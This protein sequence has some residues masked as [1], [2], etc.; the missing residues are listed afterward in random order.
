MD[1][2]RCYHFNNFYFAGL[3]AGIQSHHSF[4]EI[5]N[6]HND[7]NKDHSFQ[8]DLTRKWAKSD[9]TV[10]V[11]NGGMQMHL[12]ELEAFLNHDDNKYPW[13]AFRESKEAAN[14]A[15]TN[16]GIILPDYIFK[17]SRV[18]VNNHPKVLESRGVGDGFTFKNKEI[19]ILVVD[20]G[21]IVSYKPKN[22]AFSLIKPVLSSPYK[23]DFSLK[24]HFYSNF[25]VEF[26]AR[27]SL[28]PLMS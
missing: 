2:T 18:I 28:C 25:E 10:I 20:D 15:L 24:S 21:I 19:D 22:D 9:K 14:S 12:E 3:H 4:M 5:F 1:N 6:K 16:V 7:D 23:D 17:M 13:A 8:L 27:M 11:L 26:M